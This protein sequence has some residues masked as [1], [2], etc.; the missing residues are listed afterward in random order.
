[1]E[2]LSPLPSGPITTLHQGVKLR[3][4]ATF[5]CLDINFMVEHFALVSDVPLNDLCL[6]NKSL[7]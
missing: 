3:E 4:F 1:M 2:R 7:Q 5:V 6:F